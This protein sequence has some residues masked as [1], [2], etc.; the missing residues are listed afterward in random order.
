MTS[1]PTL[2]SIN[3]AGAGEFGVPTLRAIV[4]AGHRVPLVIT[5]PDKPA[6]RGSKLTP[7]PVAAAAV[8]LGLPLLKTADINAETL[9]P[10]DL[11]VVIAFGQKIADAIIHAPRLGAVNL[12]ASRLPKYRGAAPIHRAILGGET[13]AGNS[14]IRLAQKMDAG[15][16]LGMSELVIG[17]LETA[18][19]LHDRLSQ[20]GVHLMLRVIDEL[21]AGR[22]VET[23]QD[24]SRAT[25]A[26]KL[27]RES[28]RIDFTGK[29][30][31]IA[32]QIRG[33]H[34]WPGCRVKLLTAAGEPADSLRLIRAIAIPGNPPAGAT[35]GQI[36]ASGH[37]VTG[38][39][40]LE[41]VELQPDGK[42]PMP[43]P[44]Y[45]RGKPWDAGMRLESAV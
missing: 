6:G 26:A 21:A 45:R 32:R 12:H 28:T 34:P 39:G 9:P 29:A 1:I 16:V 41:I 14:I 43:L 17:E 7:T 33:L 38:D 35:P 3:F 27:S 25:L 8:E 23:E 36:T 5:Q 19:E 37:I 40:L 30:A 20:D 4:A 13:I 2:L 11:L 31:D 18:G 22:Q 42:R 15:A 44:D 10:A 24:H